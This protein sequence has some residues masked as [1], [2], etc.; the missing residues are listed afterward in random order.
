M[1]Q[2]F[3]LGVLRNLIQ[4]HGDGV[5]LGPGAFRNDALQKREPTA[6]PPFTKPTLNLTLL[7]LLHPIQLIRM[8]VIFFAM[9]GIMRVGVSHV[10]MTVKMRMQN[11][12]FP[13][14]LDQ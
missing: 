4:F 1:I 2:E 9:L 14:E 11:K 12:S 7:I 5:S 10:T 8:L 6:T 13:Y 3:L